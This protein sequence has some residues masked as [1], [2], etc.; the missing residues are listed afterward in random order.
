MREIKFRAW[1]KR[2]KRMVYSGAMAI[3]YLRDDDH[4]IMQFT[5]LHDFMK[6][7]IYEGDILSF[8]PLGHPKFEN[9]YI[10]FQVFW[11]GQEARFSDWTP[12]NPIY[13]I[14]NIY[15]TPELLK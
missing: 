6:K 5:G 10:P 2:F 14:G 8:V 3:L 9:P 12:R 13:I 1:D 11:K 7:D 4:E 15:E